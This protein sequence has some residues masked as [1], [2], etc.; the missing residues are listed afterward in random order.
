MTRKPNAIRPRKLSQEVEER[1][2]F[3]IRSEGRVPG[4]A[5]PSERELMSMYQVGRPAI[6]EAMQN[7]Q[8][9][10]LVKIRHGERPRIA[11][12]TI[13]SLADQ[14]SISMQHLLT[15]SASSMGYL[16]EARATLEA[17]ITRI[18][19]IRRTKSDV[20]EL[21]R[22][23]KLQKAARTNPAMFLELDGTLHQ[24]IAKISGNPIF[25][26]M[27]HAMFNWLRAFHLDLVRSPGLEALTLQEHGDIVDAIDKGDGDAAVTAMKEHLI[28]ANELYHQSNLPAVSPEFSDGDA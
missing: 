25:E 28:R 15:H 5:M 24:S 3:L 23:L 6:R 10:G 7:L 16:K 12:P 14:M 26:A 27:S 4:D 21:R 9:M 19:A 13:Q 8:R 20:A 18:A 22:I 11:A 17:E 1:L 2:L